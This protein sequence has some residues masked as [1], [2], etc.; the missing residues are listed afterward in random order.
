MEYRENRDA[1]R[2]FLSTPDSRVYF[3][4]AAIEEARRSTARCLRRNEGVALVVGATGTGKTLLTRVLAAEFEAESLVAVVAPTRRID[5]KSFWQQFLFGL[6]QTFCGCDE[7]ELR[8]MALDYLERSQR[9]R[10]VLLIDDAQNLPFRVFDELRSFVDQGAAASSQICVALFGTTV[11][12][13]RLNLPPLYPFQQRIVS[14]SY[15]DAFE[16]AEIADYIDCE[17]RRVA[18]RFVFTNDAKRK[19]ADLCKGSPRVANQLCDR[20]LFLT[21]QEKE[22]RVDWNAGFTE[23]NDFDGA[24]AAL[25]RTATES[26]GIQTVDAPLVERA[27]ANLL[28]LPEETPRSKTGDLSDVVEFGTLED[29]EEEERVGWS[30]SVAFERFDNADNVNKADN[31]GDTDDADI[32]DNGDRGDRGEYFGN[33][34][35]IGVVKERGEDN[36]VDAGASEENERGETNDYVAWEGN[37]RREDDAFSE[38]FNE[39]ADESENDGE[40]DAA[41][42]ARLLQNLKIWENANGENGVG[43]AENSN[44]ADRWERVDALK[45]RRDAD[46]WKSNAQ[47]A[48]IAG[49]GEV[50]KTGEFGE[51]GEFDEVDSD[52]TISKVE[53]T[54]ETKGI[55][56]ENVDAEKGEQKTEERVFDALKSEYFND[57][58]LFELGSDDATN[59]KRGK[60][61]ASEREKKTKTRSKSTSKTR[62]PIVGDDDG[63]RLWNEANRRRLEDETTLSNDE[64]F[65]E[66][67][68]TAERVANRSVDDVEAEAG[69]ATWE[70]EFASL[71]D[72]A[73]EQIV[74]DCWE[75]TGDVAASD[76]Y[77]S[78]L[79]LLEQEIEE[80]A[81]LIRRIRNIHLK[82]RSVRAAVERNRRRNGEETN[83]T[84][85]TDERK[86]VEEV[87][88]FGDETANC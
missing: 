22:N 24:W 39:E 61:E 48:E 84:A 57:G 45:E 6:R 62:R 2:P 27:W 3:P 78:E 38:E 40:V 52:L 28:N 35:G 32:V 65:W 88:A 34:V 33:G 85:A 15:L 64:R 55:N 83:A 82:L 73:Y 30:D 42:E 25:E 29:D 21:A 50:D 36:A 49:I 12:E 13:E 47:L 53:R 31:T 16:S 75:T 23:K 86:T 44:G 79:S 76:E 26:V 37:A 7:T 74:E 11:L 68:L 56:E 66:T 69:E 63:T 58:F 46:G 67:R 81:N 9:R 70:T 4:A 10:C 18:G 72:R 14:R 60:K 59:G 5:A 8:L 1:R 77:L 80:E 71:E 43:D 54:S 19:V 17:A 41:L 20:A 87:A 51:I